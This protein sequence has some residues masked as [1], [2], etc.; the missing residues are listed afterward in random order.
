MSVCLEAVV[1]AP[2]RRGAGG[3]RAGVGVRRG[4]W[5]LALIGVTL[6]LAVAMLPAPARATASAAV[7]LELDPLVQAFV[8][9]DVAVIEPH[10]QTHIVYRGLPLPAVLD[11]VLG[12]DWRTADAVEF[13]CADGYRASIEVAHLLAH[14]AWLA[15]AR[16]DGRAFELDNRLQG[17]TVA[18]GPFYLVW[19]TLGDEAVRARGAAPWPYQVVAVAPVSLAAHFARAMPPAEASADARR[20]FDIARRLCLH[21]HT[22]NGDGGGKAGE[23]NTPALAR[24]YANDA[25]LT[26]WLVA[27]ASLK[28]GTTMPALEAPTGERADTLAAVKAWLRAMTAAPAAARVFPVRMD[29]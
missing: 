2:C 17:E 6:L 12:T 19:D 23:L 28:P 14:R 20:G 21:C 10:N 9:E 22:M 16:A 4:G 18:L 24:R 26:A 11:R 29:D 1:S 7:P 27:P 15:H 13:V 25:W 8:A 3:V 5:P